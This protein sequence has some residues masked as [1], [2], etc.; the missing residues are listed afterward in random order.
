M[1]ACE[2]STRCC[3]HTCSGGFPPR[4]C[5]GDE[6]CLNA[7]IPGLC[8]SPGQTS[9]H[10]VTCCTQDQ[11]CMSAGDGFGTCC[12]HEAVFGDWCCPGDTD[13]CLPGNK[14]CVRTEC[15]VR[16]AARWPKVSSA[17]PSAKG[18]ICVVMR[19]STTQAVSVVVKVSSTTMALV[20]QVDVNRMVFACICRDNAR[21]GCTAVRHL[22]GRMQTVRH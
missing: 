19:V 9:C 3:S 14:C 4:C 1:L 15:A 16:L 6:I 7:F 18:P 2:G 21:C 8:C 12:P 17:I 13:V 22:V 10:G 11:A 20:V 5:A